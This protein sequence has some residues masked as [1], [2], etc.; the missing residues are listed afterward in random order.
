MSGNA[1]HQANNEYQ[2]LKYVAVGL[3]AAQQRKKFSSKGFNYPYFSTIYFKQCDNGCYIHLN[4]C[5][6]LNC[7]WFYQIMLSMYRELRMLAHWHQI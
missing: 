1:T 7:D 2:Y 5:F 4:A 3:V 6:N